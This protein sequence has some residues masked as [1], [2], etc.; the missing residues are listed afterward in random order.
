MKIEHMAYQV[1][2]ATAMAGWY[3]EHLGFTTRRSVEKPFP[4]YFLADESGD[5]MIEIYSNPTIQT[6]E[7]RAMDPLILHLAFVCETVP[8]T[9]ERLVV[10]GAEMISGPDAL[11][12]GDTLAMLR[13][14]WGLAIQL[15]YRAEPMI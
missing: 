3:G 13:D 7:Y 15:C 6:P 8:A 10:A 12:T 1:E 4:V 9:A 11:P 5:V 2:D 14:P